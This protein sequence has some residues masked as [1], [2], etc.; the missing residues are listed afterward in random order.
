MNSSVFLALLFVK[1]AMFNMT[2]SAHLFCLTKQQFIFSK[3]QE[4]QSSTP[5]RCRYQ[6]FCGDFESSLQTAYIGHFNKITLDARKY[7]TVTFVKALLMDFDGVI[8]CERQGA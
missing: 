1:F 2:S 5:Q 7:N 4:G 8:V 6:M 3:T